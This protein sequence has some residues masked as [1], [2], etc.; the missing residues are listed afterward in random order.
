MYLSQ[1]LTNRI[2]DNYKIKLTKTTTT[3]NKTRLVLVLIWMFFKLLIQLPNGQK[4]RC[5]CHMMKDSLQL[6]TAI[7]FSKLATDQY[8]IFGFDN[9][10]LFIQ[11]SLG[12]RISGVPY[13][14]QKVRSYR[15]PYVAVTKMSIVIFWPVSTLWFNNKIITTLVKRWLVCCQALFFSSISFE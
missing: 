1:T 2:K 5:W 14:K 4:S 12:I 11:E 7:P 10:Y 15:F 6:H 9:D 8:K 13:L 3:I